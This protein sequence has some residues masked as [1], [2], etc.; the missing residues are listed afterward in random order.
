M[1]DNM[2]RWHENEDYSKFPEKEWC[3]YDYMAA[4]IRST[5]YKPKTSMKNL[6]EMIFAYYDMEE[7][8]MN[9]AYYA[10]EDTREYPDNLMVFIP[11]VEAYVMDN[12]GLADFDFEW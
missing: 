3:D 1:V 2:G 7:F 6:I 10:V 5:G 8:H 4:W 9:G 11:D 12:G